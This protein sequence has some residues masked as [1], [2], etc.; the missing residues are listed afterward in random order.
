MGYQMRSLNAV[1]K[2]KYLTVRNTSP[3]FWYSGQVSTKL[4]IVEDILSAIRV[5]KFHSS[6]AILSSGM[7]DDLYAIIGKSN[8]T[9][10][11][12]FLDNDNAQVKKNQLKIAQ[13]LSLLGNVRVIKSDKDPKEMSDNELKDILNVQRT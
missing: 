3:L 11:V 5:S 13:K 7:P 12:I 1:D 2:E 9:D 8:Y 4:V 6:I 10:F